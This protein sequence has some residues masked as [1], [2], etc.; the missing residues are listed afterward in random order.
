MLRYENDIRNQRG[1]VLLDV[2]DTA[3][4]E[5]PATDMVL[6]FGG[7]IEWGQRIPESF[8]VIVQTSKSATSDFPQVMQTKHAFMMA[9]VVQ[10]RSWARAKLISAGIC[11]TAELSQYIKD[12]AD[13]EKAKEL[14]RDRAELERLKKKLGEA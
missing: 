12:Q 2:T 10:L 3:E 6:V 4:Y 13:R 1:K 11:T 5:V 7:G 14:A 9:H 8:S